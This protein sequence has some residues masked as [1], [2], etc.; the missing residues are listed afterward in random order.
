MKID[1]VGINSKIY[2]RI[3]KARGNKGYAAT[4]K[5]RYGYIKYFYTPIHQI[6]ASAQKFDRLK[7]MCDRIGNIRNTYRKLMRTPIP[8]SRKKKFE[9]L[10]KRLEG[11]YLMT[12]DR[13]MLRPGTIKLRKRNGTYGFTTIASRHIDVDKQCATLNY[14]GKDNIPNNCKICDPQYRSNMKLFK[15]TGNLLGKKRDYLSRHMNTGKKGEVKLFV[16]D[17]RMFGANVLFIMYH[18][19]MKPS[20]WEKIRKRGILYYIAK[21]VSRQLFNTP[22]VCLSHYVHP[23]VKQYVMRVVPDGKASERY[24]AEKRLRDLLS[25][26]H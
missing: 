19:R 15:D 9:A 5:N 20:T 7:H 17:L 16:K 6:R 14:I 12:A 18:S 4:A 25:T 10:R 8:K 2:K 26:T 21:P 22:K 23:S 13:C 1:G 3:E 24:L 11:S